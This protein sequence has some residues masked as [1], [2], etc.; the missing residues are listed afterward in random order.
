[1]AVISATSKKKR[2]FDTIC[3]KLDPGEFQFASIIYIL[4]R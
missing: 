3:S 4:G 2:I 1:M